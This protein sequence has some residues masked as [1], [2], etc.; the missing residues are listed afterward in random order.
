M[1]KE[2]G[3]EKCKETGMAGRGRVGKEA[4]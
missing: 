1:G 3:S 4:Y 2:R